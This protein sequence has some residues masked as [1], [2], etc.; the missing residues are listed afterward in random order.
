MKRSKSIVVACMVAVGVCAVSANADMT[1]SA[2]DALK[3]MGHSSYYAWKISPILPSGE[4]ITGA[5]LFFDDIRNWNNAKNELYVS[6]LDGNGLSNGVTSFG[7]YD[8]GFVDG[9]LGFSGYVPL[10][11]LSG[12]T[13]TPVDITIDFTSSHTATLNNYFMAN[14]CFAIG[15]DPDCHFYDNGIA[16]TL[17]TT[18]VPVPGAVLLGMLGLGV[19]GIKLRKHA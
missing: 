5:S 9:L 13:T 2:P 12:F 18:P 6:L 17:E 1:F 11:T 4:T 7:D 10:V 14:G 19:A 8:D 15:F 3:S 16:L